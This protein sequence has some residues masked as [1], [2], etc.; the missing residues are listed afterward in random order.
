MH[1]T[2]KLSAF[3]SRT[4]SIAL[5]L[6]PVSVVILT[7]V[8]CVATADPDPIVFANGEELQGSWDDA[9]EG[10]AA[11]K[12]I[13]FAV[14]PVANMRW[15]APVASQPRSGPQ[16][17]TEYA[18]ACM[19]TSYMTDWYA[20]VA[21]SFD[22]GPEAVGR[23]NSV[24]E[25]CLYLNVWSPLP[26]SDARLPV[27]VWV[28][29]G[30]NRGGWSY[31]PNYEGAKLA[32]KGVIVV[33]I[34][35]RLGA[36]G[37][38]SH[39]ALDNG[40]GEPIANFGLLDVAQAFRWVSRNIES[41]GGD[42]GNITLMGESAG[43]GNISDLVAINL[44]G[45]PVYQKVILQ[46]SASGLG[47]RRTLANEWA[48]GQ[49][50]VRTLGIEDAVSADQL[51]SIPA[52]DLLAA[53]MNELPGHYFDAV[54]DNLT[55][56]LSPIETLRST[57]EAKL[58]VLIGTNVDEW[59][60]YIDKNAGP[61]EL[62]KTIEQLAPG[63]APA[64]MAKVSHL[65]DPRRAIDRI[66]SAKNML[67]PSRYLAARVTELGGR[68]FVYHFSRQ[69]SGAGG[70]QLGAYHGTEIPYVF[71]MHDDWMPTEDIDHSLTETV[72]DYWVQFARS[73]DPNLPE[74]PQWPAYERENSVVMELGDTIG[75][76]G[77]NDLGLCEWLGP[78][79]VDRV[80]EPGVKE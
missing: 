33:T 4:S 46:S 49:R 28:H 62:K 45:K 80:S 26:G 1:I 56:E 77:P 71:D 47:E 17:A 8:G 10:I 68:A 42:P 79:H 54:I 53:Y 72:M 55:M 32:A 16:R 15:R 37:F 27:I 29:G 2:E 48:T 5:G 64:L 38:F 36:F 57:D 39:P 18:P 63:Q 44:A 60:M 52:E 69:R 67:C 25:D 19:Q 30:S 41:F 76:I 78:M 31:E 34:A 22:S 35:Y 11:F 75:V 21:E 58:D 61:T 7:F 43:A 12:G 50:L 70:E 65:T 13:P 74:R 3:V 24:S 73:G 20:S 59:Y 9:S 14:P 23:P 66:Q 40:A 51:R 6:F